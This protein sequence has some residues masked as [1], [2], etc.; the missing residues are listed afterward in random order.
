MP[1][2][3]VQLTIFSERQRNQTNLARESA[4]KISGEVNYLDSM[5]FLLPPKL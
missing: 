2:A 5:N 1:T 4:G 3:L